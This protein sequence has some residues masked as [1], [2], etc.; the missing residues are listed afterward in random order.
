MADGDYSGL[1]ERGEWMRLE[2][3]ARG[4]PV[5]SLA[6]SFLARWDLDGSGEVEEAELPSFARPILLQR[7]KRR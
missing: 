2:A 7:G 6:D 4:G 1:L 3:A 5:D